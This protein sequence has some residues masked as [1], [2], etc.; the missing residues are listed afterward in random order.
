MWVSGR[1]PIKDCEVLKL[2]VTV[3]TAQRTACRRLFVVF[4]GIEVTKA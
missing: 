3:L 2:D 1:N 4:E